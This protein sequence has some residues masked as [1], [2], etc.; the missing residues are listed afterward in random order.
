M[1]YT[2][3]RCAMLVAF[4]LILAM[5]PVALFATGNTAST[6]PGDLAVCAVMS[7]S[8]EIFTFYGDSK[9]VYQK[10]QNIDRNLLKHRVFAF[11]VES[12]AGS[13]LSLFEVTGDD[14]VRLGK[15]AGESFDSFTHTLQNSLLN[16][17]GKKCAGMMAQDLIA[18]NY[19]SQLQYAAASRPAS[20]AEAFQA[21]ADLDGDSY[22]R[23]TFILLC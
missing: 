10:L 21:I 2:N 15:L 3:K 9:T 18:Q 22:V 11:V 20:M 14:S 13:H 8:P 12:E 19:G 5:A 6:R 7:W 1:N 4:A 17:D 16:A 23:A